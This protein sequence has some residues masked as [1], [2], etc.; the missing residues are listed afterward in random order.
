M[1]KIGRLSLHSR[2]HKRL[3]K[4][5]RRSAAAGKT[6]TWATA[7]VFTGTGMGAVRKRLNQL[8]VAGIL[9]KRGR[10]YQLADAQ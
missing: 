5:A 4:M 3:M 9:V 7:A 2:K 8:V 10:R 6:F 1:R